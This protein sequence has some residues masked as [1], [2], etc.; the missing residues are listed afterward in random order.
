[1]SSLRNLLTSR[2]HS[3]TSEV[4]LG[5]SWIR[6]LPPHISAHQA[7]SLV[8]SAPH[9]QIWVPSPTLYFVPS[10]LGRR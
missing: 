7:P 1:M 4:I 9:L 6:F 8:W 2:G 10:Q 3:Q 5:T